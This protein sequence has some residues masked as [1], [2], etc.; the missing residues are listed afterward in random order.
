MREW[1]PDDEIVAGVRVAGSV[2][3]YARQLG[4]SRAT[5]A[6]HV[7]RRN[8]NE[9]VK[10][11]ERLRA[12]AH[13]LGEPVSREEVLQQ[14]VA[15]L[16]KEL[17][18]ARA[19]DVREERVLKALETSLSRVVPNYRKAS[20]P[21]LSSRGPHTLALLWSD[22][23]ASEVVS[24]TETLG[25]NEYNWGIMMNRLRKLAVGVRS[26]RDHYGA[27]ARKLVICSLGDQLTGVIHEELALTNDTSF[28]DSMVRFGEEGAQW[29]AE[30]FGSEFDEIEVHVVPGNHPRFSQKPRHKLAYDNADM[31]AGHIMRI[32]LQN[33]P[34]VRVNVPRANKAIIEICRRKV[35][36]L[37]GE[38]VRS[39]MV[40]VPWGG[41]MRQTE[42]LR[43]LFDLVDEKPDHVFC[44]HWHNPQIA[45]DFSILVN[46][47]V[48][49]IDEYGI[50]QHGGGKPPVQ[51]L[52]AFHPKWGITGVHKI[53]CEVG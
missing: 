37:H 20:D 17:A 5:L 7:N 22:C 48:K 12:P 41:I 18:R 50:D 33:V 38:G 15:E 30:E 51:L 10:V 46:G 1:P 43:A 44:G 53:D 23:H 32:A 31:V 25:L 26:H 8:L 2:T 24:P 40:G 13:S 42:R 27:K 47:S 28:A 52:A 36:L 45:E 3:A 29:I 21:L 39:T 4:V 34:N 16:E 9:A 35:L 6:S 19:E 14:R 11:R 49:G